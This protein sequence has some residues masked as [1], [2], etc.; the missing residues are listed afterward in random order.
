MPPHRSNGHVQASRWFSL[1]SLGSLFIYYAV[2][3][4]SMPLATA[5]GA[6]ARPA[7]PSNLA[8]DIRVPSVPQAVTANGKTHAVYELYLTNFSHQALRLQSIN[9]TDDKGAQDIA[10][11]SGE[12]LIAAL[13]GLGRPPDLKD[14][15]VIGAGLSVVMF[16]DVKTSSL[17]A[18]PSA[19]IH[20]VAFAKTEKLTDADATIEGYRVSVDKRLPVALASPLRG[21]GW[22]ASHA[23]SNTSLHRRSVVFVDGRPWL[24]QRF[25]IDFIR[26]GSNGQAFLGDPS[27]NRNW[28]PYGATVFAVG[29]GRIVGLQDWIPE[30]DPTASKKAVSIDLQTAAGN[31]LIVDLGGGNF[32]L[33]AHLQPRSFGVHLGDRV[34]QGEAL[35]LLGNSGNSDAPHLHFQ[36]MNANSPL[37][38]DG[39]PYV[40]RAFTVEGTLPSLTVLADGKGWRPSTPVGSLR[41]D[42]LPTENEVLDFAPE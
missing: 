7:I 39:R 12:D 6:T 38:A 40:F 26:I 17:S 14:K 20:R 28:A 16:L 11:Y 24:A 29:D 30:N 33:Y 15:L 4:L 19:L 1:P 9:V 25:A 13:G 21:N 27:V 34:K 32:A 36:I 31:Y 41:H 2:V 37:E 10:T 5:P 42:D 23:L 35:A 18:M 22:V 8:V 3:A